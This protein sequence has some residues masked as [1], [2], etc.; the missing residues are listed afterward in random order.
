MFQ[1]SSTTFKTLIVTLN[2]RSRSVPSEYAKLK[3]ESEI[4]YGEM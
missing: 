2:A 4:E 3:G 1:S